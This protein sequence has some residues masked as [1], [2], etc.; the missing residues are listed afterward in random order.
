MSMS[1]SRVKS[2]R[3]ITPQK[4]IKNLYLILWDCSLVHCY[5]SKLASMSTSQSLYIC[6][7]D[8]KRNRK[9]KNDYKRIDRSIGI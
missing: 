6:H 7:A 4:N 1:G 9:Q 3:W 8:I 5:F 2:K